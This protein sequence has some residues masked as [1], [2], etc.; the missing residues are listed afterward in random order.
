MKS[1]P[2]VARSLLVN[3][4]IL[5][6]RFFQKPWGAVRLGRLAAS[7]PQADPFLTFHQTKG[8]TLSPVTT[9]DRWGF[10]PPSPSASGR[11]MSGAVSPSLDFLLFCS[12]RKWLENPLPHWGKKQ[13]VGEQGGAANNQYPG[14]AQLEERVA[15]AHEAGRSSRPTRTILSLKYVAK[16]TYFRGNSK[17]LF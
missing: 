14:V 17:I 10:V 7:Y 8:L 3:R 11:A 5:G 15:W 1:K 16:I 2:E 12:R 9:S 6:E 13:R 4:S